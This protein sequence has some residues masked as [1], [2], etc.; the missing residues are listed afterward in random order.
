VATRDRVVVVTGGIGQACVEVMP[1]AGG[2]PVVLDA[3]VAG[4]SA[5]PHHQADVTDEGRLGAA[6]S[7]VDAR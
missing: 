2:R 6:L 7:A 1:A 5:V 3:V 4:S